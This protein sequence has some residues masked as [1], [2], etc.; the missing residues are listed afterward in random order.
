MGRL[1]A[2]EGQAKGGGQQR[3][4]LAD[5]IGRVRQREDSKRESEG[6]KGDKG[7]GLGHLV[8]I[9]WVV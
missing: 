5:K 9:H 3:L 4:G 6:G 8:A 7:F 2:R 1:S